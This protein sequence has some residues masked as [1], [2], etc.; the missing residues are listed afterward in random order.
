MEIN[1]LARKTPAGVITNAWISVIGQMRF[2]DDQAECGCTV[3]SL[4]RQKAG[5]YEI[6]PEIG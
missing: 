3:K 4:S 2:S 1:G 5:I 6:S